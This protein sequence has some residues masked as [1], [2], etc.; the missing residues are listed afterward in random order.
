MMM[1]VVT[2]ITAIITVTIIMVD[3]GI[4]FIVVIGNMNTCM[5]MMKT[6]K[7]LAKRDDMRWV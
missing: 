7:G 2:I 4:A 6:G 5:L 3:A 1:M